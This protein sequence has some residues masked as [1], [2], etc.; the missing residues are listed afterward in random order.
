M[1]YK[2]LKKIFDEKHTLKFK[3]YSLEYIIESVENGVVIYP[4]IYDKRKSYYNSFDQLFNNFTVYNESII[5]SIN[6]IILID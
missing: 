4:I 1:D 3:L 2:S 6:R 5:K